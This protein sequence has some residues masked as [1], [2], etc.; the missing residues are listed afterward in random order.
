[1]CAAAS[2]IQESPQRYRDHAP[3]SSNRPLLLNFIPGHHH[4]ELT[5]PI[6]QT[7]AS[8]RAAWVPA[9]VP[10]EVVRASSVTL[11]KYTVRPPAR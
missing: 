8:T 9:W 4:A 3:D 6:S 10:P 2:M 7:C 11:C 5:L 1:M